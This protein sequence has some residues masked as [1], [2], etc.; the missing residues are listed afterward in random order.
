MNKFVL[1]PAHPSNS[2]FEQFPNALLYRT[3]DEFLSL[4]LYAQ[5]HDPLPLDAESRYRL[6]WKAATERLISAAAQSP[7]E[8]ARQGRLVVS[9]DAKFYTFHSNVC[10]GAVG[11]TLRKSFFGKLNHGENGILDETHP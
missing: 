10:G 4:L 7:R 3:S 1:M 8:A 11:E 6:S 2:F 9:H 5:S